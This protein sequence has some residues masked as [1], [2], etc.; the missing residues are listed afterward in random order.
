MGHLLL[1]CPRVIFDPNPNPFIQARAVAVNS[2]VPGAIFRFAS[3]FESG[4]QNFFHL[5][6]G[7]LDAT[8]DVY[9]SYTNIY[10]RERS[11]NPYTNSHWVDVDSASL[12]C[13]QSD[14]LRTSQSRAFC[15][16]GCSS[17]KTSD[18]VRC[19]SRHFIL[20]YL[21]YSSQPAGWT[22]SRLCPF[23]CRS[24]WTFHSPTFSP[25]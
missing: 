13:G 20:V 22:R 10:P 9:V 18:Q 15:T 14:L 1:N 6:T 19:S 7:F 2:G 16:N 17:D 24:Y 3:Q 12:T 25:G 21:T 4:L 8:T 11:Y 5:P 23:P